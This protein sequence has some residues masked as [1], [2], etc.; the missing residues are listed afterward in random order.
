MTAKQYRQYQQWG[1]DAYYRA[2]LQAGL[3]P[4]TADAAAGTM[5]AWRQDHPAEDG[6]AHWA[7]VLQEHAAP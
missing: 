2:A 4:D 3:D 6:K 7:Q 1:R 5:M